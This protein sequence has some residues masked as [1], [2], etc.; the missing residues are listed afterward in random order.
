LLS[1]HISWLFREHPYLD[2]PAAARRAGFDWIETAWPE[3]GDRD[4][5]PQA[6]QEQ[7]LQVALL[8]CPAG[9]TARGDRGFVND[10]GRADEVQRAFTAAAHLADRL[11][12]RNLNLLVGR[13]LPGPLAP[14]REAVISALRTLAPQAQARG[15]RILVE[16]LNEAEKPGYLAPTPGHVVELIEQSGCDAIGLLLDTY[17]LGC[18]GI[19]PLTAIDAHV[20]RI[21]HVQV[22]DWPGR[23]PPGSGE[24]DLRAIL[25]RLA[26]R[27][28]GGAVGLEYDPRGATAPTLAFLREDQAWNLFKTDCSICQD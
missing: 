6:V 5:L 11:G 3:D 18:A 25:D 14:Q 16:P 2:R 13:A 22:S 23:G 4:R 28:Y 24:L 27:G 15:L 21:G 26:A 10:P 20:N 1:A 12:A 19:D 8:N 7:G 17:H 9:D